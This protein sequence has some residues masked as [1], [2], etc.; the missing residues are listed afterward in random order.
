LCSP[1]RSRCSP[2]LVGCSPVGSAC[3]PVGSACSPVGSACSPVGAGSSPMPAPF[4]CALPG[5][6]GS[7]SYFHCT[8]AMR[9]TSFSNSSGVRVEQI[10][11]S[12]RAISRRAAARAS[13]F[14]LSSTNARA[15]RKTSRSL[16]DLA[17]FATS[18]CYN[19]LAPRQIIRWGPA[20]TGH[21]SSSSDASCGR[22]D[23]RSGPS[24]RSVTRQKYQDPSRSPYKSSCPFPGT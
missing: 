8:P 3:S 4:A 22:P 18:G 1:V 14:R 2:V 7:T 13:F 12:L 9:S 23:I 11:A 20:R 5:I 21:P 10:R 24:P 15:R 6:A 19:R 16:Q 17:R